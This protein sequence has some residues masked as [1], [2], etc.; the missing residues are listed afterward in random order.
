MTRK[1]VFTGGGTGG[2]VTPAIAISEGLRELY[3]DVVF[4]YVGKKGKVEEGMVPKEW[5]KYS[6]AERSVQFVSTTS[7][8]LKSPK[9]LFQLGLGFVQAAAFLLRF[10]PDAVVATGGYVSAPIVFATGALK[11]LGLIKTKI[12][13]HEANA[14][15]GR[16]NAAA[17]KIADKVAVSFPG[18]KVAEAKKM[19]VGYP[20]RKRLVVDVSGEKEML[21]RTARE[22]MNIPLDA[23]VVFAFGGS[24]GARTINRGIVDALPLLLSDPNVVV[25]HGTGKKMPGNAYY[26]KTDVE[27]RLQSIDTNNLPSD[28]SERYRY[29]DFIDNMGDYYAATDLVVCRGGAGSLVEVCANGIASI[30]IPKANLP[31]DHQAVNARVLEKL[32]ATKVLYERVDIASGEDVESIEPTELSTLVFELLENPQLR[33]TMGESARTQYDST[34]SHQCASIVGALLGDC[35]MPA[36]K[37]EP[38][39]DTDRILGRTSGQL[40]GLLKR[41]HSGKDVLTDLERRLVLY[42]LDGWSASSGLVPPARACRM[43]GL[44]RFTERMDVLLKFAVDPKKSPFTRRDACKGLRFMGRFD[45]A[46]ANVLLKA[47]SD[48]YFETVVEAL[49]ALNHLLSKNGSNGIAT[50][51]IKDVASDLSKSK[52]FDVRMHALG[53]QA[54]LCERFDE[55]RADFEAN[56]FHPNW[57]V[58]ERMVE[59]FVH[60]KKTEKISEEELRDILENRFLHTSYGFDTLFRLKEGM[61]QLYQLEER[62]HF[63]Q[64]FKEVIY[65]EHSVESKATQLQVLAEKAKEKGL[66]VD[67]QDVLIGT[68][69]DGHL[70]RLRSQYREELRRVSTDAQALAKLRDTIAQSEHSDALTD[71]LHSIDLFLE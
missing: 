23:K 45:D 69:Q 57:Q 42:K 43:F 38:E 70:A 54:L 34:T 62:E 59:A 21:K 1:I 44:G 58:R 61:I 52:E 36:S 8:S 28:W 29:T 6:T 2:H 71:V 67:I 7:G 32:N 31:G 63:L 35:D 51:V 40:E 66:D 27:K 46:V 68:D 26:G 10:R 5:S 22:K 19:F 13:L 60:L 64:E 15:L 50:Q 24:Q 11:K 18:T 53:L 47:T 20:V 65:S 30:T 55:I 56:Y 39:L 17:V 4:R 3:P 49:H 33:T 37:E 48:D 12:M 9:V 41:V 16:M 14:E 25:L